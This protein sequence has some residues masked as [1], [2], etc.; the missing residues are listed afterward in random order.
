MDEF[1]KVYNK[2][3]TECNSKNSIKNII[4]ESENPAVDNAVQAIMDLF[5]YQEDVFE[6]VPKLKEDFRKK[7]IKTVNDLHL[8]LRDIYALEN[9]LFSISRS[10]DYAGEGDKPMRLMW[11]AMAKE[12]DKNCRNI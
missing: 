5:A 2:I 11:E 7:L 6:M 4:K 3:I 12:I 10:R 8:S 9:R 1:D